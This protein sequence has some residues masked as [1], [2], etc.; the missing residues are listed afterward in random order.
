MV[1]MNWWAFVRICGI[2]WELMWI[3]EKWGEIDG[4]LWELLII[5]ENWWE[6]VRISKLVN[7]DNDRCDKQAGV[8]RTIK[9]WSGVLSVCDQ[10]TYSYAIGRNRRTDHKGEYSFVFYII[11]Q[12]WQQN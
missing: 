7:K 2:W 4:N 1:E 10:T 11:S 6:L 3:V 12:K 9:E 8:Q 5:G